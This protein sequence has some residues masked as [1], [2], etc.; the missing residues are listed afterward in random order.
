MHEP[1]S[2]TRLSSDMGAARK[3][4]QVGPEDVCL[5]NRK[6]ARYQLTNEQRESI[7]NE[8]VEATG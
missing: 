5:R 8:T 1:A 3:H 7:G 6:E 4:P 2:H